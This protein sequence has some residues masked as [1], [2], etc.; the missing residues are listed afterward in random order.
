MKLPDTNVLL[1][2]VNADAAQ[3]MAARHWM[4]SALAAPAGLGM[5]WVALLG[6]VRIATRPGIFAR[7]LRPEQ[8]MQAVQHWLG[9]PRVRV[10]HPAERHATLLGEL[11]ATAGTA[12]NLSTDAHLAAL[13][14]EHGA[15]LASF[16][17]DFLRFD[18]LAFELLKK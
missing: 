9:L 6:F 5:A 1:Y 11:L 3:H 17:R 10:L 12:G 15:T 16:D 4:V 18:G 8:A 7:P 13:C 14:I 2:S